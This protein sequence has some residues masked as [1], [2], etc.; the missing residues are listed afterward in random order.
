MFIRIPGISAPWVFAG[1]SVVPHFGDRPCGG[2]AGVDLPNSYSTQQEHAIEQRIVREGLM[3]EGP[4][5]EAIRIELGASPEGP[6]RVTLIMEK[7]VRTFS[8]AAHDVL[9]PQ[10]GRSYTVVRGDAGSIA[11]AE[12]FMAL[13]SDTVA[14]LDTL[15][16]DLGRIK[17]AIPDQLWLEVV[18]DSGSIKRPMPIAKSATGSKVLR[19]DRS[20]CDP[21]INSGY[22]C[23]LRSEVQRTNGSP[24]RRDS[25]SLAQTRRKSWHPLC[26]L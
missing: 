12:E 20:I 3:T 17:Q 18:S 6:A 5:M 23:Q 16:L 15:V 21:D 4:L 26:A 11:R 13:W 19:L 1:R 25:C 9:R 7:E 24:V 8:L 10:A 14:V 2:G 22:G